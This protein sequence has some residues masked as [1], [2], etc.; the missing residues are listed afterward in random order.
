MGRNTNTD[1]SVQ[2]KL[3]GKGGTDTRGDIE[4]EVY[5]HFLVYS[6]ILSLLYVAG[7]NGRVRY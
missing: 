5:C 7:P 2:Q 3:P 6:C 1:M 4:G